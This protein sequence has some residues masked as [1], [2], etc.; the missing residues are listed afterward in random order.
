MEKKFGSICFAHIRDLA[1]VKNQKIIS[2]IIH[3]QEIHSEYGGVV[4]E[5]ASRE[6]QKN[7]VFV[8]DKALDKAD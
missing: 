1:V 2:N 3:S 7:I 6:H 8:V 4:P 5:I